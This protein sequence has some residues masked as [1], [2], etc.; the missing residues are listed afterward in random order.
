MMKYRVLFQ[1]CPIWKAGER[2]VDAEARRVRQQDLAAD[3]RY[4]GDYRGRAIS[5]IPTSAIHRGWRW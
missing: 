4:P 2:D 3:E 5:V 1:S